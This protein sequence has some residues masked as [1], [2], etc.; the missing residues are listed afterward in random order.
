M[1]RHIL[2]LLSR[3]DYD[4]FI[5]YKR[6]EGD[7]YASA[8]ASFLTE[9]KFRCYFDQHV[10]DE[11]QERL[12]KS[13]EIAARRSRMLVIVGS[14]GVKNSKWIPQEIKY[15][16]KRRKPVVIPID[17]GTILNE[18]WFKLVHKSQANPEKIE[19]LRTGEPTKYIKD[20]IVNSFNYRKRNNNLQ[21]SAWI[22]LIGIAMLLGG[23]ALISNRI[24]G[25][26][27]KD[28][29]KSLVEKEVAMRSADSASV[30]LAK[31]IKQMKIAEALKDSAVYAKTIA[32]QQTA[33]A[34]KLKLET[35]QQLEKLDFE[36][37]V[38]QTRIAAM[39]ELAKDPIVSYRLAS[40]A[41]SRVQDDNNREMVLAS[42]SKIDLYYNT[43]LK[44]YSIEDFKEPFVLLSNEDE[45]SGL[46]SFK[47]YDTKKGGLSE[48]RGI[49]D[50]AWIIPMG[51]QWRILTNTWEDETPYYQLWTAK[52]LKIGSPVEGMRLM[53]IQFL[54]ESKVQ[55]SLK[56][57][58][59]SVLWDLVEDRR[60]EVQETKTNGEN[61][62]FEI[63]GPMATRTDKKFAAYFENGLVL[64]DSAGANINGTHT[65]VSFDPSSFY[66]AAEWS[67][68]DQFLALNYF[69]VKSL[70][71][72]NPVTASFAWVDTAGWVVNSYAWSL[73][74]HMLAYAGRTEND[75]D[76]SIE[77]V[78]AEN[79]KTSKK[80]IYRGEIPIK[81]MA[82][83]PGDR[84][85]AVAD[86]DG[87]IL[88]I[89]VE[90]GEILGK[91]L[92][93][94]IVKLYST[95]NS[96]FSSGEDDFRVWG[97]QRA[98]SKNWNFSSNKQRI[99]RANGAA[100]N[101]YQWL[102][103]PYVE[104]KK[105]AGLE[106]RNVLNGKSTSLEVPDPS[107]L[108]LE[109]TNDSKWLI[110]QTFKHLRIWRTGSWDYAD[111]PLLKEDNQ[112]ITMVVEGSFLKAHVLGESEGDYI[113]DL[114]GQAAQFLSKKI[115]GKKSN[116][117]TKDL[118]KVPPSEV[119]GWDLGNLH[120]YRSAGLLKVPGSKWAMY[121]K[122]RDQALGASNCD[123]QFIPIDIEKLNRIYGSILWAPGKE[124]LKDYG[125]KD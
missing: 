46:K 1:I 29:K 50:D 69:N 108:N 85:L 89:D 34:I 21:L 38:M 9:E 117:D 99:Y 31:S 111:F 35:E 49:G 36:T 105:T 86:R 70:G 54:T 52:G 76:V 88:L 84:S 125:L 24:I 98:P 119:K 58:K 15:Y 5:S 11:D 33:V 77:I 87:N 72:W 115:S 17:F 32:D 122:C 104:N 116:Q 14:E 113:I 112:Y 74:G 19:Y 90:T 12:P 22:I 26:A 83:L 45:N 63:Y 20:I 79:P 65:I 106:I 40:N 7:H 101:N 75:I 53:N 91:G 123:V 30:E 80:K 37:R 78:D 51:N 120:K 16:M 4:I 118:E 3:V 82:F 103:V 68:D 107:S 71:I 95:S 43:L 66:S 94:G 56:D 39:N 121:I 62:F 10:R 8:L 27:R 55:I 2:R 28:V 13:I 124:Q 61:Y 57:R 93:P 47:V 96:L 42:L 114:S 60:E 6:N 48:F 97:V 18:E 81:S 102:A 92:Q 44:G 100:D 67:K 64:K 110:L 23:G 25:Q 109:F 59:A 73:K 41:Y